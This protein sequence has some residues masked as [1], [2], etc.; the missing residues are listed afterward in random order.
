MLRRLMQL[1]QQYLP[2]H[3]GGEALHVIEELAKECHAGTAQPGRPGA[4][5]VERRSLDRVRLAHSEHRRLGEA[6]VP[7]PLVI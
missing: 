4:L 5:A 2:W 3:G 1:V 7:I 6:H